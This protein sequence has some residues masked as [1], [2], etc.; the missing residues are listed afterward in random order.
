MRAHTGIPKWLGACP[1]PWRS[2]IP[3]ARDSPSGHDRP[4]A[5]GPARRAPPGFLLGHQIIVVAGV[6][7]Q[8]HEHRVHD[9]LPRSAAVPAV[10][11]LLLLSP[12]IALSVTGRLD[13]KDV[14]N[15]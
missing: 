7:E 5:R 13:R 4:G 8:F 2:A 14:L 12:R 6:D 9:A 1:S 3:V 10:R 11:E 15:R